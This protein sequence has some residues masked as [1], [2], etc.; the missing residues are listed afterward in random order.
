MKFFIV[1]FFLI[2]SC[3]IG[4][5]KFITKVI[6]DFDRYSF[7]VALEIKSPEYN[8]KVVI[9]NDDLYNYYNKTQ[10]VDKKTYQE[11]AYRMLQT[12]T[13]LTI[14]KEDLTR[15]NFLIVPNDKSVIENAH[16]GVEHFVATYFNGRVLKD[17]ISDN[18]LYVII[19]QLY[20]FKI[21][22]KIDDE[23]GYL[24]IDKQDI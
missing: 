4:T 5:Q 24:V 20:N 11:I 1:L 10:D 9:E 16:R 12:K 19:Y 15:F 13:T 22:S 18:E 14:N 23:T 2:Q 3:N 7:F 8:G 17:N 21:A 6:S